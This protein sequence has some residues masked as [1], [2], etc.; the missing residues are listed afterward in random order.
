MTTFRRLASPLIRYRTGDLVSVDPHPCAC[1]RALLRLEGGL[2]GRA[3]DM[4][5]VR[6]NNLHPAT[7]QTILHRF[8]EVAEYTVEID[9]QSALAEVRIAVEPAAGADGPVLARR[10]Q[11]A[12][13]DELLFRAEVLAVPAGSLPRGDMKARRWLRKSGSSAAEAC[14]AH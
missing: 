4:V 12:I 14:P 11:Q 10:V 13:R 6:G 2:C 7:L 5:V 9:K 1:G 3:D 8:P